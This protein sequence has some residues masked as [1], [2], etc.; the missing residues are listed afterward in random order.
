MQFYTFFLRFLNK[1][2]QRPIVSRLREVRKVWCF[3]L[4]IGVFFATKIG[5]T[6]HVGDPLQFKIE[7]VTLTNK[8][9]IRGRGLSVDTDLWIL[10]L[11][12]FSQNTESTCD[13]RLTADGL[14]LSAGDLTVESNQVN[15]CLEKRLGLFGRLKL[16]DRKLS[17]NISKLMVKS[18]D[19]FHMTKL[20][21]RCGVLLPIRLDADEVVHL[22]QTTRF[23]GTR[24]GLG[25]ITV[26]RASSLSLSHGRL[27]F[28]PPS[29]GF[30]NEEFL[31]K[32]RVF[33]PLSRRSFLILEPGVRFASPN[34]VNPQLT[35]RL[36]LN[37]NVRSNSIRFFVDA[38]TQGARPQL[39]FSKTDWSIYANGPL[40][41][42]T[43]S[44]LPNG[45]L[46][47]DARVIGAPFL[48]EFDYQQ[49]NNSWTTLFE[50]Y[51]QFGRHEDQASRLLSRYKL[52]FL[53][54]QIQLY[55]ESALQPSRQPA[56]LGKTGLK[57]NLQSKFRYLKLA[58]GHDL[59]ALIWTG[60]TQVISPGESMVSNRRKDG[61]RYGTRSLQTLGLNS[62]WV[63][64]FSFIT[65]RIDGYSNLST[66]WY[67]GS[68]PNHLAWTPLID[69]TLTTISSG[70]N[71]EIIIGDSTLG[72]DCAYDIL[73][74]HTIVEDQFAK[75]RTQISSEHLG[76]DLLW[77]P[78]KIWLGRTSVALGDTLQVATLVHAQ[79]APTNWY[80]K[81]YAPPST[82]SYTQGY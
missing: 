37:S 24:L 57:L 36:D 70:I 45:F 6:Q 33:L 30:Q 77:I 53:D 10:T 38:Q 49:K 76:W 82:L 65:H 15:W 40:W 26:L 73:V 64:R 16:V 67:R 43:Q 1:I 66:T 20:N 18:S 47:F 75:C 58:Y 80:E 78:D 4:G 62:L 17:V 52:G 35:S 41:R 8:N 79:S 54:Q 55:H 60:Q 71:Q 42:G 9:G 11:N 34:V 81:I 28:L 27:G 25:S 21:L 51:R 14:V 39:E 13:S 22:D 69:K 72:L 29:I 61:L 63:R 7:E 2:A 44:Q 46:P 12:R 59:N 19:D 5:W 32:P 68:A 3:L 50:T 74:E 23:Y 48:T 31:L 56:W